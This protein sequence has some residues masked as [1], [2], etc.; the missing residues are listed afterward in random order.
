MVIALS[1]RP[2]FG[3]C[4]VC[5]KNIFTKK[6]SLN[7]DAFLCPRCGCSLTYNKIAYLFHFIFFVI[8]CYACIWRQETI[9]LFIGVES[10]RL[11]EA[12]AA[13]AYLF[14]YLVNKYF[15]GYIKNTKNVKNEG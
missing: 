8:F 12:S 10:D 15:W 3:R 6:K 14:F 11:Y 2:S 13:I 7:N 4:P 9:K 5:E 1:L